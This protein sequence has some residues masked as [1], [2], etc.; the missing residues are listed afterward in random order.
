MFYSRSRILSA[1]PFSELTKFSNKRPT[2]WPFLAM[3]LP[4][5]VSNFDLLIQRNTASVISFQSSTHLIWKMTFI[6]TPLTL[7]GWEMLWEKSHQIHTIS[8]G[9]NELRWNTY[10]FQ[11][12]SVYSI[13]VGIINHD[14]FS[15]R[16]GLGTMK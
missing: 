14:D 16:M 13:S 10:Y 12:L 3:H 1:K 6:P 2:F 15:D 7:D 5:I 11:F 4:K 8:F 9:R